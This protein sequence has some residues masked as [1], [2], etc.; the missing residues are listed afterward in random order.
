[1]LQPKEALTRQSFTGVVVFGLE[2]PRRP[3]FDLLT[4]PP[5]FTKYSILSPKEA[6]MLKAFTGCSAFGHAHLGDRGLTP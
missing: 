6:L 1:M 4:L 5:T 3:R 2:Q